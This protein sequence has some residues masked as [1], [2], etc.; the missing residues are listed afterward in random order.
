MICQI[1]CTKVNPRIVYVLQVFPSTYRSFFRL[2]SLIRE[3][4]RKRRSDAVMSLNIEAEKIVKENEIK[5]E[6]QSCSKN[7]KLLL[8]SKIRRNEYIDVTIISTIERS[9]IYCFYA[10]A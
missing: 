6:V 9:A 8:E 1:Q 5:Q 4:H 3:Q 10:R 7:R 2:R